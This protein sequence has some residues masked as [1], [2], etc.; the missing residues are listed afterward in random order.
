[1]KQTNQKKRKKK[2]DSILRSSE[3]SDVEVNNN[4]LGKI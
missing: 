2:K 4:K 1:M 3:D